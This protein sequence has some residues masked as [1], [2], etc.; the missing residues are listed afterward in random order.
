MPYIQSHGANLYCEEHG[1][2]RPFLFSHGLGSHINPILPLVH[3]LDNV[4]LILYD[5]RTHGRT[6]DAGNPG[7]LTFDGMADDAAAILTHLRVTRAVIGGVSMGAGIALNLG[8]RRPEMTAAMV[9]SRPAWLH[10]PVPPNLAMFPGIADLVE[11]CG[12]ERAREAFAES[13]EYRVLASR[14]PVAAASILGLLLERSDEAIIASFRAIPAS[15]PFHSLDELGAVEV[16]VLV[17]GNYNDPVHPFEFAET[18]A[19]ALPRATLRA[20]I[21]KSDNLIEHERQFRVVLQ[22]FLATI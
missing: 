16:P 2:G 12:R 5:N 21:S 9:L 1:S 15:A 11:R 20:V 13:E 17:V 4:R 8:L 7:T 10:Y 6:P 14:F 22:E 18:L 19:A 3:G